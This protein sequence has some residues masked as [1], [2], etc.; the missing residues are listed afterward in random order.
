MKKALYIMELFLLCF[1]MH[2]DSQNGIT[3]AK[4]S[5][6]YKKTQFPS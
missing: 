6:N 1:P 5:E 3:V 2:V 4:Y